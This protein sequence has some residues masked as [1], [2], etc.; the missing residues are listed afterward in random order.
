M[1][2]SKWNKISKEKE[3]NE[4][5]IKK[6]NNQIFITKLEDELEKIK[7]NQIFKPITSRLD[8]GIKI[9]KEPIKGAPQSDVDDD[10]DDC[11]PYD[12]GYDPGPST[13]PPPQ[14]DAD[15]SQSDDDE[16]DDEWNARF[17][18]TTTKEKMGSS[19]WL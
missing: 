3:E 8:E 5:L 17:Y 14:S 2:I 19:T 15:A 7:F 6:I 9:N 12:D 13:K 4:N 16:D 1:S 11:N 18:T 10:Y